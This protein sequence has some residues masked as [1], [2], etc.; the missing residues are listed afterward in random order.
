MVTIIAG[1]RGGLDSLLQEFFDEFKR[2]V[3][4]A[5]KHNRAIPVIIKDLAGVAGAYRL[6]IFLANIPFKGCEHEEQIDK[7]MLT[8]FL[9]KNPEAR[10]MLPQILRVMYPTLLNHQACPQPTDPNM[11]KSIRRQLSYMEALKDFH[12][13]IKKKP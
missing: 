7:E 10:Q 11:I 9:V 4:E 6:V 3:R 13:G 1:F 2:H 8:D 5:K 12:R